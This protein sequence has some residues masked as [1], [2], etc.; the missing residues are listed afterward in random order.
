MSSDKAVLGID[1]ADYL[2]FSQASTQVNTV[3]G[4]RALARGHVRKLLPHTMMLAGVGH[5]AFDQIEALKLLSVDVPESYIEQFPK[6]FNARERPAIAQCL[7]SRAPIVTGEG[8]NEHLLSPL[9]RREMAE[10]NI[11]V[12]AGHGIMDLSTNMGTHFSFWQ[13]DPRKPEE[14]IKSVLDLLCP[15]L[16]TALIRVNDLRSF[17]PDPATQLTKIERE[18]LTWL[19][20]GRTNSEMA[21][22]RGR[23]PSTIRNQLEGLYRKLGVGNRTEAAQLAIARGL[24]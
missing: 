8:L 23:S 20:A 21:R 15:L 3:E 11:G 17:Q 1:P 12:M 14:E 2:A 22:M 16:H 4:F 13:V 5:L 18:I 10:Y 19:A 6:V 7:E 24:I 9:M